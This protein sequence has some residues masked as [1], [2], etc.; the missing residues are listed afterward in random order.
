MGDMSTE[1]R[2][3][4]RGELSTK[5][6]EEAI[7]V[8]PTVEFRIDDYF[9]K[10]RGFG[11]KL[12]GGDKVE[13]KQLNTSEVIPL[14]NGACTGRLEEWEKWTLPFHGSVPDEMRNDRS[15]TTVV[16][17]RKTW[18]FDLHADVARFVSHRV[19]G[20]GCNLEFANLL[21]GPDGRKAWTIGLEAFGDPEERRRLLLS[22]CKQFVVEA[23]DAALRMGQSQS[24]PDWLLESAS[25]AAS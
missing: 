1:L 5:P 3:F 12:R 6:I 15:W 2:W 20:T 23:A 25:V 13:L 17:T 19:Q 22:A 21:I 8:D 16:K 14:L 9:S 24:Y 4:G 11:L 7:D 18:K 10:S